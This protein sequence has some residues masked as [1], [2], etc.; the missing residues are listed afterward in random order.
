MRGKW[1]ASAVAL[2][3][4]LM[5]AGCTGG[6]VGGGAGGETTTAAGGG[7]GYGAGTTPS[8]GAALTT[9][10]S[11]L[12]TIVVDGNGMTVYMFDT[13][14]KGAASSACTGACLINWPPVITDGSQPT[15]DGVTGTVGLIAGAEGK[16]Q[17]TLDGWPLYLY[18]G[19][20]AAGDL[21]GQG[22]GGVWWV[23][24][25]DGTPIRK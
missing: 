21:A 6:Q 14:T 23:L 25:P 22:V 4:L 12:G 7:A 15:L 11:S 5:L 3:A 20:K 8:T 10:D 17:V 19:D 24:G 16:K 1:M 18:A 2:G 13:D 9:M